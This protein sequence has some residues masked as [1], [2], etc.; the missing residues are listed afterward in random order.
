MDKKQKAIELKLA[1]LT[2]NQIAKEL[3]IAKSTVSYYLNPESKMV[4][5]ARNRRNRRSNL[6]IMQ[7]YKEDKGC[8][9]CGGKFPHY[10]LQFDHKPEYDKVANVNQVLKNFGLERAWEEVSKCD[11]VCGNCHLVRTYNRNPW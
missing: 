4:N 1:G 11:V 10:V 3:N 2:Q 5:N 6:E 8:S 7:R 9:D